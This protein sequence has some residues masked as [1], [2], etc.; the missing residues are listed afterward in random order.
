[1]AEQATRFSLQEHGSAVLY[2]TTE[3]PLRVTGLARAAAA[4]ELGTRDG[5]LNSDA[6]TL[7]LAVNNGKYSV[8]NDA[9]SDTSVQRCTYS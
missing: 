2:V 1:M 4:V 6:Q 7:Q 5:R 3:L 9:L 8:P